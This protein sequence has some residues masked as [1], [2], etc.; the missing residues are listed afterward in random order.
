MLLAAAAI[1]TR[2]VYATPLRFAHR[3]ATPR[4]RL[5]WYVFLAEVVV[6]AIAYVLAFDRHGSFAGASAAL[7]VMIVLEVVATRMQHAEYV[8]TGVIL[9]AAPG[10]GGDD[11]APF[12]GEAVGPLNDALKNALADVYAHVPTVV[13]AYL[14][15][16]ASGDGS[17]QRILALR[18]AYPWVDEN[19]VRVAFQVF[20]AMAAAGDTMDVIGLDERSE[21]RARAVAD[22]FY[23]RAP[24]TPPSSTV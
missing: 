19:A 18:Y 15:M 7:G 12:T 8:R 20:Q 6:A 10:T 9:Q 4:L 23:E 5:V 21:A 13:R 17:A 2:I 1:V 16:R 22:P 24:Q 11:L 14:V 3:N